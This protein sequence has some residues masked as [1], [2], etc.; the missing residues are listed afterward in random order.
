MLSSGRGLDG[1]S[2]VGRAL[3]ELVM[4]RQERGSEHLPPRG[5]GDQPRLGLICYYLDGKRSRVGRLVV[6]DSPG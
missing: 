4:V 5:I 1:S 2:V 6:R 3:L